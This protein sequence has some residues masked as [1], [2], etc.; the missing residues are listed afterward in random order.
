MFFPPK[1][2]NEKKAISNC[3]R[4]IGKL[5]IIR[6]LA[7]QILFVLTVSNQKRASIAR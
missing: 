3:Y 1:I 2:L 5:K 7:T 6:I 4:N